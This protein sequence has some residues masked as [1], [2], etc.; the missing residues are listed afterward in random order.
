MRST[1]TSAI[2][3]RVP[4]VGVWMSHSFGP[5]VPNRTR[6]S[7]TAASTCAAAGLDSASA[8]IRSSTPSTPTSKAAVNPASA[9]TMRLSC[10]I[11][12]EGAAESTSPM[13]ARSGSRA[14]GRPSSA[15]AAAATP[16]PKA[17]AALDHEVTVEQPADER[18]DAAGVGD[19][20]GVGER[21]QHRPR[22]DE[23]V[24]D[25]AVVEQVGQ[26]V[27]AEHPVERGHHALAGRLADVV[28]VGD[29]GRHV[30]VI[31]EEGVV[32]ELGRR[33]RRP[34]AV[35]PGDRHV[36]VQVAAEDVT[37][38]GRVPELAPLE[39]P[40]AHVAVGPALHHAGLPHQGPPERA[41]WVGEHLARVGAAVDREAGAR[42]AVDQPPVVHSRLLDGQ[43]VD[44]R[45][46][47][48]VTL[49]GGAQKKNSHTPSAAQ[50][51]ASSSRSRISPRVMPM[52]RIR[53]M[54]TLKTAFGVLA[55]QHLDG[56]VVR[57]DRGDVAVVEPLAAVLAEPGL[58]GHELGRR[59]CARG[60]SRRQ[61]VRNTRMS[62]RP[63][64][65]AALRG[66]RRLEILGRDDVA[67]L[68]PVDAL[69]A[70]DVEQHPAAGDTLGDLVDRVVERADDG[71]VSGRE[72]VVHVVVVVDVGQ[73]VP[74][75][76][77]LQRHEDV[78]V[79]VLEPPGNT[80]VSPVCDIRWTGLMRPPP[81][82]G[83]FSSNGMPRSNTL[84]WRT[85]DGRPP[86]AARG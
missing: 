29:V 21:R 2:S 47:P 73:R 34:L 74:L 59:S 55:G 33:A 24:D 14:S 45:P 35:G 6:S 82:C 15:R 32:D 49:S 41:R 52:S 60:S 40:Q 58:A 66:H 10:H 53:T 16:G 22:G 27:G 78:V 37:R 54:C 26:A 17:A 85:S 3:G 61:P 11:A 56:P 81:G 31:A 69:Q 38:L 46:T 20:L 5:R 25:A 18:H 50:S 23:L 7:S 86:R 70:G 36:D 8:V 30:G 84:P 62:P 4:Q 68:Q 39:R 42:R 19:E 83:P 71:D 65:H 57:A 75:R 43:R 80:W 79:G 9:R 64:L 67:G 28:G 77:A 76:R 44:R 51:A 13:P 48:L 1:A 12:T 63:D 72:A